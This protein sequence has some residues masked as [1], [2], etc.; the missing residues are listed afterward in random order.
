MKKS[1]RSRNIQAD[2]QRSSK[3]RV[4]Y[5]Q[6]TVQGFGWVG[7][8]PWDESCW[9]R[10][11]INAGGDAE[12]QRWGCDGG[13][14]EEAPEG[15]SVPGRRPGV[16]AWIFYWRWLSCRGSVPTLLYRHPWSVWHPMTSAPS[17]SYFWCWCCCCLD[18]G[19]SCSCGNS[20]SYHQEH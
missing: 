9:S 2:R 17:M 16:F 15:Q 13:L 3:R 20:S 19:N 1:H 7:E 18:V 11:E 4:V 10:C 5:W 12:E 14:T 8:W 6:V